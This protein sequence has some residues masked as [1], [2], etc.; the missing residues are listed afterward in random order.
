MGRSLAGPVRRWT[1]LSLCAVCGL[2]GWRVA[3]SRP[4]SGVD[5]LVEAMGSRRAFEP[6]LRGGFRHG[7]LA[8]PIRGTADPLRASAA[9]LAAAA[10]I[11]RDATE[12]T[13]ASRQATAAA[14]LLLGRVDSAI[15]RLESVVADAPDD[16]AVQ[17]DLAAAYLVRAATQGRPQDLPRALEAA[18]LAVEWEP[19]SPESL[20]N[21]ALALTSLNLRG[22]A[23][24]AWERYLA[25][26]PAEAGWDT[27]AREYLAALPPRPLLDLARHR[28]RLDGALSARLEPETLAL[29]RES[30]EASRLD[31]EAR[32]GRVTA[33][34][35]ATLA[36]L[37]RAFQSA[38]GDATVSR[39][40]E[41]VGSEAR[42]VALHR[43]YAEAR[44][45]YAADALDSAEPLFA[46]LAAGFRAHRSPLAGWCELHIAIV[47]FQRGAAASALERLTALQARLADG[48]EPLL[49]G[50]VEWMLGILTYSAGRFDEAQRHYESAA[51]RF[52]R[53]GDGAHASFMESSVGEVL[54]RLGRRDLGWVHRIRAFRQIGAFPDA[55]RRANVLVVG[56]DWALDGGWPHAAEL[57]HQEALALAADAGPADR[58]TCHLS[59]A[60]SA[61]GAHPERVDVHLDEARGLIEGIAD[62][63]IQNRMAGE[64]L[65]I[66]AETAPLDRTDAAGLDPAIDWLRRRGATGRLA[67]L[68]LRRGRLRASSDV[69][70]AEQDLREVVA[71]ARQASATSEDL[72]ISHARLALDAYDALLARTAHGG[73]DALDTLALAEGRW[74]AAD[75]RRTAPLDRTALAALLERVPSGVAIVGYVS[76]DTDLWRWTLRTGDVQV[77]RAP[78]SRAA[79]SQLVTRSVDAWQRD[80]PEPAVDARLHDALFAGSDEA[81]AGARRVYVIPSGAIARAPL[82][83]LAAPGSP[84][85]GERFELALMPSIAFAAEAAARPRHQ[86]SSTVAF[87][88]G[89]ASG[90]GD[91]PPLPSAEAEAQD[92]AH[93]L[94]GRAVVGP[95]AGRAA[96]GAGLAG[97][98][99]VHFAGHAVSNDDRPSL[100]SL[101]LAGTGGRDE[102]L[103][104]AEIRTLPVGSAR[105][106]FLAACSA[107]RSDADHGEGLLTLARP[108]LAAGAESV[109][110]PLWNVTDG[111]MRKAA[112][113]F[114][115][116]YAQERDARRALSAAL[117]ATDTA[118]ARALALFTAEGALDDGNR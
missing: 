118:D 103:T 18:T 13:R 42:T 37:G 90:A 111:G 49:L 43:D 40:A 113:R 112:A 16:A 105:L 61:A 79:L 98:A 34:D 44:R 46:R 60:R 58:A 17:S 84:A 80:A 71:L 65:R 93:I 99:V 47:A 102:H 48:A 74:E 75:G 29:V 53:A 62:A 67:P 83:L 77:S 64:L 70:G 6:R 54:A 11:E 104:A 39:V 8:P 31:F 68:L 5:A 117:T 101:I 82:A 73:A 26:A 108:F 27:A 45:L 55:R 23:R 10:A 25:L 115:E 3:L 97:A 12:P 38:T 28:A 94:G 9:L 4:P 87:A 100:S 106:V 66:T 41:Q 96:F 19:A 33:E 24:T 110:A 114:Y 14:D 21:H 1:A 92:V 35:A 109:I 69:A 116:S 86:A 95:R 78:V 30:V 32:L 51:S 85:L 36:L 22:A 56:G 52:E 2:V 81:L 107:G 88:L 89:F 59:L 20:Y 50:R 7:P 15:T 57:I 63:P 91:L 72:R 76:T